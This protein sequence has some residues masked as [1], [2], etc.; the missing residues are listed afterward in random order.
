MMAI[1]LFSI[2]FSLLLFITIR[3][4]KKK[5]PGIG[6]GTI[7]A[8][9]SFK[10]LLGCAYGYVFLH[11]YGGD[12]TWWFFRD[13]LPEYQKMIHQPA[14]FIMDCSPGKYFSNG[15][16]FFQELKIYFVDLEYWTMRKMLAV[17]NI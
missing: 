7:T 2:Y 15:K 4:I 5:L 12:D 3:I 9:F 1:F 14:Q 8:M 10:V 16:T 13:S 11:Y 17:F 6:F